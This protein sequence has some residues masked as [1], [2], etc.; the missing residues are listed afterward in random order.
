MFSSTGFTLSSG[1]VSFGSLTSQFVQTNLP[2]RNSA[3]MKFVGS[4]TWRFS[5]PHTTRTI[6]MT[7]LYPAGKEDP[8]LLRCLGRHCRRLN[9][10]LKIETLRSRYSDWMYWNTFVALALR[11]AENLGIITGGT[12][13]PPLRCW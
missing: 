6:T 8:A 10:R 5:Q 13:P 4:S 9:A 3:F 1:A 11:E 7:C 2:L 12:W